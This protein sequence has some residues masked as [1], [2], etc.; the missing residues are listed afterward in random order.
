MVSDRITVLRDGN[1]VSVVPSLRRDQAD[2]ARMMVGRDVILKVVKQPAH[3]KE[4]R[5]RLTDVWADSDR[6]LPRCAA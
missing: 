4:I 1:V 5:L 2:L 3:P 6:G